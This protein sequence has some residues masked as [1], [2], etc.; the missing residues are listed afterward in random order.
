MSSTH[1]SVLLK[2]PFKLQVIEVPDKKIIQI[3][4]KDE[5]INKS[6]AEDMTA[7]IEATNTKQS[8]MD[9]DKEETLSDSET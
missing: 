5:R 1:N 3:N 4:N 2:E 7:T 9:I 6:E 8:E